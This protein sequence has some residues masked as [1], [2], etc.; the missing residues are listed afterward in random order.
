MAKK[1]Q[2]V[3][4]LIGRVYGDDFKLYQNND[5]GLVQIV[6]ENKPDQLLQL[7]FQVYDT[8]DKIKMKMDK[9]RDG[10]G[11]CVVCCEMEKGKKKMVKRKCNCGECGNMYRDVVIDTLTHV[12][13]S[14]CEYVCG[15]CAVKFEGTYRNKCPICRE[16]LT[17]YRD[18]HNS[19]K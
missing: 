8:W 9:L 12:C 19:E 1:V 4:D 6:F 17:K 15:D 16:T 5:D 3:A 2:V 18:K 14:C 11:V 7:R 10:D 13:E